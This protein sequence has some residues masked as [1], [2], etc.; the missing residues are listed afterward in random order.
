MDLSAMPLADPVEQTVSNNGFYPD[1]NLA[2]LINN[3]AVATVYGNNNDMAVQKIRLAISSVNRDLATYKTE[4]WSTYSKLVDVPADVIDQESSLVT[5]YK[6]AVFSHT[7]SLLF[8]SRL[9]ETNRDKAAANVQESIDNEQHWLSQSH[10]AIAQMR[11]SSKN[12]TVS[13]I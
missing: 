7:K 12:I 9:G 2:E 10:G 4:I 11:N 6:H 3:Y 1:L 13:L 5:L 8:I